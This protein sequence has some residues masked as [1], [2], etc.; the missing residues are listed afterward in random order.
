MRRWA[1]WGMAAFAFLLVTFHRFALGAIADELM[2][3][4][5]IG[6]YGLGG[7]SS[8]YFYL[9]A[10]LQLPSGVLAD[11]LGPRR[12][13]FVSALLL[14]F[15]SSLFGLASNLSLAYI[16]RFL[17]GLGSAAVFVNILKLQAVWFPPKSFAT[18]TGLTATVGNLG[19]IFAGA[20]FALL[21]KAIGWRVSF[22]LFGLLALILASLLIA[23]VRDGPE[24]SDLG[25]GDWGL[26]TRDW[27]SLRVSGLQSLVSRRKE[28]VKALWAV[29]SNPRI[30]PPFFT[31][32][33]FDGTF[34]AFFALWGV[35]Y[36]M[37][38]HDLPRE[39]AAGAVSLGI[40]GF[41][42]LA[43]IGGIISDR[44]LARR[45]LPIVSSAIV[46]TALW[47]VLAF[48]RGRL[49]L[50]LLYL[51]L[52][53]MGIFATSTLLCLA[54]AKELYHPRAVGSA[55][56]FVNM[57]GFVGGAL[58]QLLLGY[59]LDLGWRGE[60]LSGVRVYPVEAFQQAFFFCL[61]LMLL[62][63]LTSLLIRD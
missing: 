49:P 13:L 45:K 12:T 62:A 51:T 56:A 32:V 47:G 26:E 10:L 25:T 27:L 28:S 42:L 4:W 57:G 44:I 35:P 16:G 17:I 2:R 40:L 29:I 14:A 21:A 38:V 58:M 24:A 48:S 54:S 46:Y 36:L 60:M 63:T 55:V 59:I 50:L 5:G 52:F 20:P 22:E 23:I 9:Y 41:L 34:F 19:A 37:Q 39:E 15:G 33:G 31:R 18:M 6:A 30:W 53:L 43:P 3:A 8:L 11:T 1:I 61:L 7:L